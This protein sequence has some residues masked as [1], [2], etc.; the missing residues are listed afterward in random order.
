[1][2]RRTSPSPR[3]WAA[4]VLLA[5]PWAL[6]GQC[7][8]SLVDAFD[9]EVPIDLSS[10]DPDGCAT[11]S[12][13]LLSPNWHNVSVG[14]Q[15]DWLP[16]EGGTPTNGTG[17]F[18]TNYVLPYVPNLNTLGF[19]S[20]TNAEG[21][22]FNPFI[23]V[24]DCTSVPRPEASPS[25]PYLISE[26]T[27]DVLQNFCAVWTGIGGVL[28]SPH[29][30]VEATGCCEGTAVLESDSI[31]M[32]AY[33]NIQ[34]AFRHHMQGATMGSLVFETSLDGGFTWEQH[35]A[36]IG[37]A[38]SYWKQETVD[39]TSVLAGAEAVLMRFVATVVQK[40]IKRLRHWYPPHPDS[41]SH[42]PFIS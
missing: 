31:S 12:V 5:A 36:Q 10:L 23:A 20:P 2:T 33:D 13:P 37:A 9:D 15:T 34:L 18:S 41:W 38:G 4:M 28:G 26:E 11:L 22:G 17:P 16:H 14:D 7:L 27:L 30:V 32:A 35:W 39:L 21:W 6:H 1:M 3:L 29:L 8:F 42:P 24:N 19:L 40:V 25:Q